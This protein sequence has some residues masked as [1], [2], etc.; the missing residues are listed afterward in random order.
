MLGRH[1]VLRL[2]FRI[3]LVVHQDPPKMVSV[4]FRLPDPHRHGSDDLHLP[5]P[6]P[7]RH[8]IGQDY[9]S[10]LTYEVRHN[11]NQ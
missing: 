2:W 1:E 11:H 10:W 5:T 7:N 4:A 9:D 3:T 6:Y 8:M